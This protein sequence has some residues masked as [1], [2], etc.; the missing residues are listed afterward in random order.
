MNQPLHPYTT[1]HE[2]KYCPK[3]GKTLPFSKFNHNWRN[4]GGYSSYCTF[5]E[6]ERM[7]EYHQRMKDKP[8]PQKEEQAELI[9]AKKAPECTCGDYR[10]CMRCRNREKR[11]AFEENRLPAYLLGTM[12]GAALNLQPVQMTA[13]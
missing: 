10:H 4:H 2:G 13:A 3:C 6:R 8:K 12:I 7:R 5:H 11:L 9:P 1:P